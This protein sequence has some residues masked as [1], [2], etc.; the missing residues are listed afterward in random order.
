MCI[1]DSPMRPFLHTGSGTLSAY[2]YISGSQDSAMSTSA[3]TDNES[4]RSSTMSM[5][6][7]ESEFGGRGESERRSP[8]ILHDAQSADPMPQ[9]LS[10][11]TPPPENETS[12]WRHTSNRHR[13]PD[14]PDRHA[15]S[16]PTAQVPYDSSSPHRWRNGEVSTERHGTNADV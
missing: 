8:S 14:E 15:T 9:L 4:R 16:T 2:G 6:V 11:R 13:R 3:S 12:A 10:T 5:S 7:S 1:R